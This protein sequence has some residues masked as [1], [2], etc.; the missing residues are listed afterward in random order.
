MLNVTRDTRA[1]I[2]PFHDGRWGRGN[3]HPLYSYGNEAVVNETRFSH[4]TYDAIKVER[5]QSAGWFPHLVSRKCA[6][7]NLFCV[8]FKLFLACGSILLCLTLASKESFPESSA[9]ALF[10]A[11][12][13]YPAQVFNKERK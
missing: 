8:L 12:C 6:T 1:F 5:M 9:V 11:V 4:Q 3:P 10:Y 13:W 7:I 2:K